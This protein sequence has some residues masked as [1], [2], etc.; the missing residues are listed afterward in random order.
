MA[1]D[2]DTDTLESVVSAIRAGSAGEAGNSAWQASLE[3]AKKEEKSASGEEDRTGEDEPVIADEETEAPSLVDS[4]NFSWAVGHQ[5]EEV[6]VERQDGSRVTFS[7]EKTPEA[8]AKVRHHMQVWAKIHALENNEGYRLRSAEAD[9]PVLGEGDSVKSATD[10]DGNVIEGLKL[11]TV[12]DETFIVADELTPEH[13]SAAESF[14]QSASRDS[15]DE[16]FEDHGLPTA[17]ETNL[18]GQETTVE[19]DDGEAKTVSELYMDKLEQ[20]VDELKTGQQGRHLKIHDNAFYQAHKKE[21]DTVL[22]HWDKWNGSDDIVSK[23]D[24]KKIAN[25]RWSEDEADAAKFLLDD[26]RSKNLLGMLDTFHKGDGSDGKISSADIDS[27]MQMIG[28][29]PVTEENP[30]FERGGDED[31]QIDND[32]LVRDVD[33]VTVDKFEKTVRLL[34]LK[35]Q[36]DDGSF[37]FLPYMT[38]NHGGDWTYYGTD[39]QGMDPADLRGL[40]DE[41]K[42]GQELAKLLSDD[43][44]A[45]FTDEV[46]SDAQSKI[47]DRDALADTLYDSLTGDKGADYLEAMQTLRDQGLGEQAETRLNNDL[48]ALAALDPDRA[49]EARSSITAAAS[50]QDIESELADIDAEYAAGDISADDEATAEQVAADLLPTVLTSVTY[51]TFGVQTSNDVWEAVKATLAGKT[52]E[53]KAAPPT[54]LSLQETRAYIK[55][56]GIAAGLK[57][58]IKEAALSGT[59]IKTALKGSTVFSHVIEAA[60]NEVKELSRNQ[61][62]ASKITSG[63]R[64]QFKAFMGTNTMFTIGGFAALANAIYRRSGDDFG[65]TATERMTVARG[66]L[67]FI[68]ITPFALKGLTDAVSPKLTGDKPSRLQTLFGNRNLTEALGLDKNLGDV[69]N[70]RFGNGSEDTGENKLNP[71]EQ[72]RQQLAQVSSEFSKLQ[73]LVQ[74]DGLSQEQLEQRINEITQDIR[75]HLEETN[76]LVETESGLDS[77]EKARIQAEISQLQDNADSLLAVKSEASSTSSRETFATALEDIFYDAQSHLSQL[78]TNANPGE[79][80]YSQIDDFDRSVSEY[81][82]LMDA[83][84]K[85]KGKMPEN[86]ESLF[87]GLMDKQRSIRSLIEQDP[88]LSEAD[89]ERQLN[90]MDDVAGRLEDVRP[91]NKGAGLG[92]AGDTLEALDE[93]ENVSGD[94]RQRFNPNGAESSRAAMERLTQNLDEEAERLENGNDSSADNDGRGN[95]AGDGTSG[96]SGDGKKGKTNVF[97]PAFKGIAFMTDFAGGI[98]DTVVAGIGLD[99]AIKSGEPMAIA[100]SSTGVAS[101]AFFTIGGAA[102]IAT[103]VQNT[104]RILTSLSSGLRAAGPI[105]NLIGLGIG[106]VSLIL[107]AVMAQKK[108]AETEANIRDQFEQFADDGVTESDWGEKFNYLINSSYGFKD[109]ARADDEDK[110][111]DPL[112]QEWFPEDMAAWEAQPEQYDKFTQEIEENG[113]IDDFFFDFDEDQMRLNVHGK[114]FYEEHKDVI[115]TIL[116]N[117]DEGDGGSDWTAGDDIVSKKDLKKIAAPDSDHSTEER[118]AAQFLLDHGDFFDLLDNLHKQDSPDGKI[119]SADIDSWMQLIGERAITD[120]NPAF[121]DE[122]S[123][124]DSPASA[125]L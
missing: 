42:L 23:S 85:G 12:D 52:T 15:V 71:G 81:R 100:A 13:F 80:L 37:Q 45:K 98:L 87:D 115:D 94:L 92:N 10:E 121:E 84:G 4:K 88:T 38:V 20:K 26:D 22:E 28:E 58:A 82:D 3:L 110:E 113:N 35:G 68:G 50:A 53:P 76:Q 18:L 9:I 111:P 122:E 31:I 56:M 75:K 55:I 120:D 124:W 73:E 102:E 57:E 103:S 67:V 7:R 97:G 90:R 27:W 49:A 25:G 48:N 24:L 65:D 11:V 29:R 19:N 78:S 95:G 17:E 86:A 108:G 96:S 60:E 63:F 59:D 70:E 89:R 118:K 123:L 64:E 114:A 61:A 106:F 43:D 116:T 41:E 107:N 8:F 47:V 104:S 72:A 46:M 99:K 119:S 62:S 117:W 83:S 101:G 51:S 34:K 125:R 91:S 39:T 66:M 109:M 93:L 54:D 14:Q 112:F 16:V 21:I 40:I 6:T 2:I 74:S 69:F 36:L 1:S 79:V 33:Q 105:G 77:E 5:D 30:I 32:E 44:I